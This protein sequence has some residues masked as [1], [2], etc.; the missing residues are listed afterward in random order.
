MHHVTEA[1]GNLMN[2][3]DSFPEYLN[4]I[5]ENIQSHWN[6]IKMK[7]KILNLT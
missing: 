7:S 5:K 3:V 1:L 6:D 2:P 4:S